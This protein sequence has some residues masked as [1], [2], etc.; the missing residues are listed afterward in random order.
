[1]V[2][3]DEGATSAEIE[4]DEQV[5]RAMKDLI[6]NGGT[7]VLV[8]DREVQDATSQDAL[9]CIRPARPSLRRPPELPRARDVG[10]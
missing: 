2:V 7:I 3:V 6:R 8:R 9:S 1:M 4:P 10:N 5:R